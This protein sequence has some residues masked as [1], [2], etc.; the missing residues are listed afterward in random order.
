MSSITHTINKNKICEIVFA[1]KNK[2]S[3]SP[4]AALDLK[5]IIEKANSPE[6]IKAVLFYSGTKDFFCVGGDLKFYSSLPDKQPGIDANKNILE[7]LTILSEASVPTAVCVNGLCLGGGVELISS[8]DYVVASN[9]SLF[10]LWQRKI[11]LS[12]G[13]GGGARLL[14]RLSSKALLQKFIDTS[15]ITSY[16]ALSIG[17]VDKVVPE[18][19]LKSSALA[20]LEKSISLPT[21][22]L[23]L[24]K[25][26]SL[27]TDEQN[28]FEDLWLQE[29][30]RSA[31]D[32]F[33]KK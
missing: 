21:Q 16:E 24:C 33:N 13:W 23:A 11:G 31:L 18:F 14:K 27:L 9:L 1:N 19:K 7:S 12:F 28:I 32:K 17:L 8:F 5:N 2:N 25:S 6:D 20:W 29:D 22:P 4:Q 3:F 15:S 30:H 10:S 26:K